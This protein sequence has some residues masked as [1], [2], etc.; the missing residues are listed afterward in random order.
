MW[1]GLSIPGPSPHPLLL[2]KK[3]LSR[4][5]TSLVVVTAC[6]LLSSLVPFFLL[7]LDLFSGFWS[8]TNSWAQHLIWP[9]PASI[10]QFRCTNN[11]YSCHATAHH[12]L[13]SISFFLHL[14]FAGLQLK[15]AMDKEQSNME[16]QHHQH[17]TTVHPPPKRG[18]VKHKIFLEFAGSLGH[19]ARELHLK[20]QDHHQEKKSSASASAS[21]AGSSSSSSPANW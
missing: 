17:H 12:G 16:K 3:S 7:L 18:E 4:P 13:A 9:T 2:S 20:P 5:R 6:S 19:I 1:A 8:S 21:S 15:R 14:S 11:I 10:D